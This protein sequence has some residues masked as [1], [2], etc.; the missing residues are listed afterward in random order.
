MSQSEI[1]LFDKNHLATSIG[2]DDSKLLHEIYREYLKRLEIF[3]KKLDLN[4]LGD[5]DLYMEVHTMKASSSSVGAQHLALLIESVE[6]GLLAKPGQGNDRTNLQN[7]RI[8]A[9]QTRD[10]MRIDVAGLDE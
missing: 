5:D 7:L 6:G 8:T 1:Q 2:I 10:L 3:I 4:D 9:I